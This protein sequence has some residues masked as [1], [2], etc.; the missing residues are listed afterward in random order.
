MVGNFDLKYVLNTD[1]SGFNYEIVDKRTLSHPGHKN[2]QISQHVLPKIKL[3]ILIQY[4]IYDKSE[5]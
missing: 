1:Q 3:P 5:W 2:L 4:A